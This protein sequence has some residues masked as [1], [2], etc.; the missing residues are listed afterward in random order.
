MIY[1]S[2][3][4]AEGFHRA[5]KRFGGP[6][7]ARWAK[8]VETLSREVEADLGRASGSG[9]PRQKC[10]ALELAKWRLSELEKASRGVPGMTLTGLPETHGRIKRL[11]QTFLALGFYHASGVVRA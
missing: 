4:D 7:Y 5:V 6:V 11:E 9:T 10:E 8:A 3:E 2:Q 1:D